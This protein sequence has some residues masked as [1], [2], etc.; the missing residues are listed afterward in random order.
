MFHDFNK[1][2]H[3]TIKNLL[4]VCDFDIEDAGGQEKTTSCDCVVLA[5]TVFAGCKVATLTERFTRCMETVF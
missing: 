5:H 2:Q 1:N 4:V 3:V